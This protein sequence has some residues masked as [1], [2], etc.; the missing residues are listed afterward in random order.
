[1]GTEQSSR[2]PRSLADDLRGRT[3]GQIHTLLSL[4]PDLLHPWPADLSHLARRAADDASVLEALG[5]LSTPRLRVLEVFAALHE[6]TIEQVDEALD[7]D[8]VPGVVVDLWNRALLWGGPVFKVVRAAQQ[9]FGAY[10][11]GLSSA[12]HLTPDPQEVT[13]NAIDMDPDRLRHLIW[14]HP[15]SSA[16]NPLTVIRGEQNIVPREV[17]L[18][19]R[20]GRF[21]APAEP[22]LLLAPVEPVPSAAWNV[23]AGVRYVLSDLRQ[24]PLACN[25]QKGVSRRV[26]QDR[27]T[28][29]AVPVDDL[30][31]WLELGAVAG[32]LG[33]LDSS[34][35][36]TAEASTWLQS[37]P[38]QMWRT[39]IEA[40][41]DSDR[42]LLRCRPDQLGCLTTAG[43]PR[44]AA[45]RREILAVWPQSRVTAQEL[46]ALLEW[47]RPRLLEAREQAP[48]VLGELT[49][50]GL[51]VGGLPTASVNKPMAVEV[52]GVDNSLIVQP[53]HT[54]IAPANVDT[55]TWALLHE[56][57]HVESWGPVVMLRIDTAH[58]RLAVT[59]RRPAEII[60][61]LTR[62][63]RTPL[64]QSVEYLVNDA[65]RGAP[66]QVSRA[67]VIQ[68]GGDDGAALHAL[69][70]QQVASQ[71]YITD[72]PVDVVLNALNQAGV[73]ATSP[74]RTVIAPPL[75]Y[76]RLQ[77]HDPDAVDR[78]VGHLIENAPEVV[79]APQLEPADPST[80]REVL[81][82]ARRVWLEFS[83]GEQTLTQ[84][85]EPLEVRSG[86]LSAWSLTAA[87]TV[88]VP[89]SRIAALR[90]ADD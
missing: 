4:R 60:A 29:M 41:L 71:T 62:C 24:R 45:H 66:A 13:D 22:P 40:W 43:I 89:L 47:E 27:A 32:L 61:Q 90:I 1:M 21:L 49:A 46:Q 70:W 15:V 56:I 79:P 2:V 7:D 64:P 11:C 9:A 81:E 67:T 86:R 44:T 84:L 85:V 88:T 54:V 17:A 42:P 77:H 33:A 83:D 74:D 55:A 31:V 35:H 48:D 69:G 10:P 5:S 53:D 28:S 30:V 51:V 34:V 80:L 19:L 59:T 20:Q 18:V 76:P 73:A 25:P 78:L 75:E 63:S 57:A 72:Q 8:D 82:E 50:L 6:A 14:E 87:R 3:P 16:A 65:S 68:V 39:L 26:L 58:L 36:P 52:P 23:L 12:S 37:T 38:D